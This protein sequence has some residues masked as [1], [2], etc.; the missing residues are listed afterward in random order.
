M[1]VN[2]G[3][4]SNNFEKKMDNKIL[5]TPHC[6]SSVLFSL[7]SSVFLFPLSLFPF[8]FLPF[9]SKFFSMNKWNINSTLY[10]P[11]SPDNLKKTNA[12]LLIKRPT[13]P[14]I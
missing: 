4:K 1:E 13:F 7:I 2:N 9:D 5:S 8:F 6:I 11:K 10:S 12:D 3:V 14:N